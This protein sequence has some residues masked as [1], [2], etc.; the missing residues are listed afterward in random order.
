MERL[1]RNWAEELD[2][3][4]TQFQK[5]VNQLKNEEKQ[6]KAPIRSISIPHNECGGECGPHFLLG[7]L[8]LQEWNGMLATLFEFPANSY[9]PDYV[10]NGFLFNGSESISIVFVLLRYN[11]NNFHLYVSYIVIR[12]KPE[13]VPVAA[14]R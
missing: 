1:I 7:L 11:L 14:Q 8:G 10:D 3:R 2:F 12:R 9:F 4:G 5:E 6:S 13:G